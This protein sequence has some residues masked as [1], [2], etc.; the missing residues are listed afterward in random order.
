MKQLNVLMFFWVLVAGSVGAQESV[1]NE[2]KIRDMT[3]GQV[4]SEQLV[5]VLKP[6]KELPKTRGLARGLGVETA[7]QCDFYR[8]QLSRGLGVQPVADVAAVEILFAFNSAEVSPAAAATLDAIGAA[9]NSNSLS[10]CCFQLEGHTD[11]VG[12]ETYNRTLSEQRAA[13]V[14]GYL[15]TKHKIDIGRLLTSG[16]GESRPIT[17]ND[18]QEGRDKNRRVQ[19]VN[20]GYGQTP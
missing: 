8:K 12:S 6:K 20:L 19:I 4:T 5:D 11:S 15:A 9:L 7:P 14:A 13:S 10:P 18:T 1:E 17:S 2:P 16:Y 3:G